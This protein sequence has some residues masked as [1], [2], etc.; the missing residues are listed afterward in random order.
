MLI[1]H[2]RIIDQW[3]P[4]NN[5]KITDEEREFETIGELED[6]IAYNRAYIV[7]LSFTGKLS[8]GKGEEE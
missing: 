7:E 1:A 3:S 6:F 5:R 2:Y 4:I 8:T